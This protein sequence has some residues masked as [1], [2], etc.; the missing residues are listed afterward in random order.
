MNS[1][2]LTTGLTRRD[3]MKKSTMAAGGGLLLGSLA[4]GNTAFAAGSDTLR[5][6]VIG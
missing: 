2:I 3:F 1:K 5:V 6:A 4:I